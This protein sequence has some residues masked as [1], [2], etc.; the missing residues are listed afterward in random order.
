MSANSSL[1]V[2]VYT[3]AIVVVGLIVG[4][5]LSFGSG[6]GPTLLIVGAGVAIIAAIMTGYLMT[7][8]RRKK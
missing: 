2:L 6:N 3:A 7:T 1:N 4:G 8:Q 5:L